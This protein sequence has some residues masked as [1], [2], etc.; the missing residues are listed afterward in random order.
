MATNKTEKVWYS[1]KCGTVN[2]ENFV[3]LC[4][5]AADVSDLR[6]AIWYK[7]QNCFKDFQDILGSEHLALWFRDMK[8]KVEQDLSSA[9]EGATMREVHVTSFQAESCNGQFEK[10]KRGSSAAV[11]DDLVKL[12]EQIDRQRGENQKQREQLRKQR[13]EFSERIDEW[14]STLETMEST[15]RS[16]N[17]VCRC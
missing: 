13:E 8:L 12:K 14:L 11:L 3:R 9:F 2:Y 1:S 17:W 7:S 10:K 5:S 4:I 6:E 15:T 16:Y